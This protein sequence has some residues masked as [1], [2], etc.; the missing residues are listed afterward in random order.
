LKIG[1]YGGAGTGLIVTESE[2]RLVDDFCG[3][4]YRKR[5][6]DA[7]STIVLRSSNSNDEHRERHLILRMTRGDDAEPRATRFWDLRFT[8]AREQAAAIGTSPAEA[9]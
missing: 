5:I 6:A 1:P 3:L 4:Y 9:S 2:R 8:F 7:G